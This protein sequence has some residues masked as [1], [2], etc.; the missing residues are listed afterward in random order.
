[1]GISTSTTTLSAYTQKNSLL[2]EQA[3][4][5][6][7][8][9]S[10]KQRQTSLPSLDLLYDNIIAFSKDKSTPAGNKFVSLIFSRLESHP[11]KENL[12]IQFFIQFNRRY[13]E[14]WW[15]GMVEKSTNHGH[16]QQETTN[17][18][19]GQIR[20]DEPTR[21]WLNLKHGINAAKYTSFGNMDAYRVPVTEEVLNR[22]I[23]GMT[24]SKSSLANAT[25]E[26]YATNMEW[27]AANYNPENAFFTNLAVKHLQLELVEKAFS[28]IGDYAP[29]LHVIEGYKKAWFWAAQNHY[30]VAIAGC[31]NGL[32]S[33]QHT[34]LYKEYEKEVIAYNALN[35]EEK[36]ELEEEEEATPVLYAEDGNILSKEDYLEWLLDDEDYDTT[37]KEKTARFN[38]TNRPLIP[39]LAHLTNLYNANVRENY[40][41]HNGDPSKIKL[42]PDLDFGWKQGVAAGWLKLLV[43]FKQ[44]I[45]TI[46]SYAKDEFDEMLLARIALYEP[47]DGLSPPWRR[48]IEYK[49]QTG[50]DDIKFKG[51]LVPIA[52]SE[53]TTKFLG[54]KNMT[55]KVQS[56]INTKA[57]KAGRDMQ[58][59]SLKAL[60]SDSVKASQFGAWLEENEN[61]IGVGKVAYFV[62]QAQWFGFNSQELIWE[63]L[64]QEKVDSIVLKFLYFYH[65]TFLGQELPEINN[66]DLGLTDFLQV[67]LSHFETKEHGDKLLLADGGVLDCGIP[68]SPPV[69]SYPSPDEI[70]EMRF[71]S[72]VKYAIPELEGAPLVDLA[73]D[74]PNIHHLLST[75]ASTETE[76]NQMLAFAYG[77]IARKAFLQR[78]L[79]LIGIGGSGKSTFAELMRN[80]VGIGDSFTS[81]LSRL[82]TSNFSTA[83]AVGK[84]LGVL[85][86]EGYNMGS[87]SVLKQ[88]T[89]KERTVIERKHH[90]P[91]EAQINAMFILIA[92]AVP[93]NDSFSAIS[94]RF[95]VINCEKKPETVNPS[96]LWDCIDELG[97]FVSFLL[98]KGDKWATE[99]ML[100]RNNDDAT[101]LLRTEV[102]SVYGFLDSCLEEVE[103]TTE[104]LIGNAHQV[105]HLDKLYPAYRVYCAGTATRSPVN[106]WH[107]L[108]RIKE[109][110]TFLPKFVG[111]QYTTTKLVGNWGIKSKNNPLLGT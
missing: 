88:I 17:A 68:K 75:L 79:M 33:S 41:S 27:I 4:E 18:L 48:R 39:H 95:M 73:L 10:V 99:I 46:K 42:V 61:Q 14:R 45:N 89:S 80:L 24:A 1:M 22:V 103:E 72:K 57:N 20:L 76:Y 30:T 37:T 111:V 100:T 38:L 90:D 96:L 62:A 67:L 32:A 3:L 70:Q 107:F 15:R 36:E 65:T 6:F 51:T 78:H 52:L 12:N 8:L 110:L 54:A 106:Y 21:A 19:L 74:C 85:P 83:A 77:C 63:P 105:G 28:G 5:E 55:T 58:E 71:T 93:V 98:Q 44:A 66:K 60:K 49:G 7:K 23:L 2:E 25:V 84:H 97:I 87:C 29:D 109:V 91:Y 94:R 102:D 108:R 34:K 101:K 56:A 86:D 81:S 35:E 50:I 16:T 92:N 43:G 69:V 13:M 26:E 82:E 64:V 104:I 40:H 53:Y 11:N 47:D 59:V 31:E 9:V